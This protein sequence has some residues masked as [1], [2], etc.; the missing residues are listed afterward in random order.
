MERTCAPILEEVQCDL[1]VR[2]RPERMALTLEL[3]PDSLEIVELAVGHDA[4][5]AILV[6]DGLIAGLEV[7]NAQP[8]MAAGTPKQLPPAEA[9]QTKS[10]LQQQDVVDLRW[11]LLMRQARRHNPRFSAERTFA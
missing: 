2:P 9:R 6:D 5:P 3:T 4:E 1:A 8:R 11:Q 10:F 7:D